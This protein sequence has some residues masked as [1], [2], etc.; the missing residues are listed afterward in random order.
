MLEIIY[1]VYQVPTE[2]ERIKILEDGIQRNLWSETDRRELCMEVLICESRDKFKEIMRE[3]WGNDISFARPRNPKGGEIYCF[4]IGENAYSDTLRRMFN[5]TE[6]ECDFCGKKVFG[7]LQER[8]K[9]DNH[10]LKNE[11][12]NQDDKYSHLNFCSYSCQRQ[13]VEQE[14]AKFNSDDLLL[15]SNPFITKDS[16]SYQGVAGWVYKITKRSTGE[17]YVGQT[18]NCPIFRWGQHLNTS[19]FPLTNINDYI[20]EIL[21]TVKSGGKLLDRESHW[22]TAERN[23]SPE[24]CLNVMIPKNKEEETKNG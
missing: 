15:S 17:F 5:R 4:I 12:L 9:I 13:F 14:K 22:I 20:F 24:R 18:L 3:N 1:R 8:T 6:Y 19:R 7:F 16:F 21:E 10:T 2:E 23:K 11:L